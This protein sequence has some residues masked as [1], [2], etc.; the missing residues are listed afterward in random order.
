MHFV[1]HF[2]NKGSQGDTE[3]QREEE[4][5]RQSGFPPAREWSRYFCGKPF[6]FLKTAIV[7]RMRI[8][9]FQGSSQFVFCIGTGAPRP[10]TF[11]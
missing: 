3:A 11:L 1:F 10:A 2:N 4:E 7:E 9:I 5:A 8:R 6:V